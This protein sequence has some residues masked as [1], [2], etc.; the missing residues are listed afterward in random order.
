MPGASRT[1]PAEQSG[2]ALNPPAIAAKP[3]IGA[4]HPVAGHQ[5]RE[6]VG[7][8]GP[9]HGAGRVRLSDP[10]GKL[11]IGHG[12]APGDR[13]KRAPDRP[14]EC[15]APRRERQV[16]I[17]ARL[18]DRAHHQ[19]DPGLDLAPG[20]A[21]IKGKARFQFLDQGISVVA[22]LDCADP[23]R[24]RR[25]QQLAEGAGPKRE[26]DGLSARPRPRLGAFRRCRLQTLQGR[27]DVLLS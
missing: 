6:W 22:E 18:L 7:A 5:D 3:A 26:A 21:P 16:E 24:R 20:F 1:F 2:L 9:G 14:L 27:H 19:P 23:A 25:D 13:A 8:A 15:R 12:R 4:H 10:S 11:A 17:G